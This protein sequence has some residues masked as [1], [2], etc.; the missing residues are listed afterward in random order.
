VNIDIRRAFPLNVL[1]S[2]K[3]SLSKR[4]AANVFSNVFA[5]GTTT[6]IQLG[7][8]PLFLFFWSREQY[9]EWLLLASIPSYLSLAE[10]GFGTLAANKVA[11]AI[12]EGNYDKA[13]RSLHTA[14]G[15][16]TFTACGLWLVLLPVSFLVNWNDLF[17][18]T[19]LSRSN[20]SMA[21]FLLGTYTLIGLSQSIFG[22]IY[23]GAYKYPRFGYVTNSSRLAELLA[24]AILV[25]S[26]HSFVIV[27]LGLLVVRSGLTMWIY[28]DCLRVSPNLRLGLKHYSRAEFA[29]T[30]RPSLLFMAFSLGNAAYFQGLTVLVGVILNPAAVV[31]FNT[32]RTLT[33]VIVQ[34]VSVIKQSI[35]PEFSYLYGAGDLVKARRLNELAFELTGL[36]ALCLAGIIAISARLVIGVWTHHAVALDRSLLNLLLFSAVL[37]ALW[38][39]TSGVLLGINKHEKL[40]VW[41]LCA[42]VSFV[43]VGKYLISAFGIHGAAIAMIGCELVLLPYALTASCR[44]LDQSVIQMVWN[45]FRLKAVREVIA[46]YRKTNHNQI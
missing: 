7:S 19:I 10:A 11:M 44:V 33:R 25:V 4:L 43:V 37:N 45:F 46:A 22:A 2:K 17:H 39:A 23:R 36:S 24:T 31:A 5:L 8:V 41:Y 38:F 3:G 35:W 13:Q 40:A 28:S 12:A 29:V 18:L 32:T 14:W 6:L 26:S 30:W 42:T 21:V 34:F 9:G 15:F 20:A 16:L 27:S 1:F